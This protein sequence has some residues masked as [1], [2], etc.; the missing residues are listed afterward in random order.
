MQ[1]AR[2][3]LGVPRANGVQEPLQELALG[4]SQDLLPGVAAAELFVSPTELE[5]RRT[6]LP[7]RLRVLTGIGSLSRQ[8]FSESYREAM[9]VLAREGRNKPLDCP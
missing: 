9:C 7:A 1:D 5:R 4:Y 8:S 3:R 6:E 2:A